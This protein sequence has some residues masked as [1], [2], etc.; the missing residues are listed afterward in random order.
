MDN[1]RTLFEMACPSCGSDTHLMVVITAWAALST[2]GTEP[3]G[4]HDWDDTSACRCDSCEYTGKVGDFHIP[5][6]QTPIEI[7]ELKNQRKPTM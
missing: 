6:P 2:D 4:D 7:A 5:T 1:V 3:D